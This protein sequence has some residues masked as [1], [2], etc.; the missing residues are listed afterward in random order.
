MTPGSESVAR[1]AA[2]WLALQPPIAA[3][4]S[5]MQRIAVELEAHPAPCERSGVLAW[6]TIEALGATVTL[7]CEVQAATEAEADALQARVVQLA[8]TLEDALA[9]AADVPFNF[10]A[11]CQN[12]RLATLCDLTAALAP[13]RAT[14]N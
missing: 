10:S 6:K 4:V 7:Y 13:Y 2:T 8:A 5:A 1:L 3:A 9:M 11:S 12:D 14:R